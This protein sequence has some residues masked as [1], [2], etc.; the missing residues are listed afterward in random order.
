MSGGIE[1]LRLRLPVRRPPT[2]PSSKCAAIVFA[3]SSSM[4]VRMKPWGR[5]A[6]AQHY[7]C[8]P[9]R[10]PARLEDPSYPPDYQLRRVRSNGEIKWA[11][12][13]VFLSMP[14]FGEVVGLKETVNGDAELYF[15][16]V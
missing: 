16:P 6:P 11:G 3:T 1:P 14:L 9:R 2:W 13:K 10:Y 7:T 12:E 15:G 5:T 8:A 4:S